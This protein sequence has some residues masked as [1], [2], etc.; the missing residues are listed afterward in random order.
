[1]EK[2]ATGAVIKAFGNLIHV[3]FEGNIKQG[4]VAYV[5]VGDK[6]FA[7]EVIEINGNEAKVQVFEDTSGIKV[8]TPVEFSRHLLEAE[9][10]PGLLTSIFDGLQNPLEQIAQKAGFF[11]SRGLYIKALDRD[12]KWA[13]T[14]KVKVDDRVKRGDFLGEVKESHFNH[15][16]MTPFAIRTALTITWVIK[17]G[18][19]NIDTIIAK[20]K[21]ENGKEYEISMVQRWPVKTPLVEGKRQS[22]SKMLTTG[23][24]L[25]DTPFPVL[26]GATFCTP[27]PFGAGKT[28]LQHHLAKHSDVDIVIVAACGERAGEV[29]EVLREFPRLIDAKTNEPLMNRTVIIC[30]TSS[31]PVAAREASVYMAVTIAEYYRQMGLDILVLADSTSR[32]AQAMREM[33][34]RLEEIPGEEAFPAY[35]ASRIAAFYERAGVISLKDEKQGSLT[36]GGAVSPAGGNFEEPVTQATLSVVGAFW[37]LSRERSDAR[38]YP[39]I[40]PLIS[41][42]KY[43]DQASKE[44]N[45]YSDSW[46]RKVNK[47]QKILR[48]G[49]EILKRMEVVGEEGI[50]IEDMILYLKAELY[51]MCYLQQN[52]F[53]PIDTYSP[54][55][56][57]VMMFD[58]L[59]TIFD[60]TFKF[61]STDDARSFFLDLQNDLKNVNYLVFESSEFKELIK[62][63]KNK[64]N[65]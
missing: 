54:I 48:H 55:N 42:T 18:S 10:G 46:K 52:S 25:L 2:K 43:L 8:N 62:R 37:G 27:G 34:G 50:S 13:F 15:Q 22:P 59:Q 29:V 21:D 40:D 33:S 63:I 20:A 17:S 56:R 64:L 41:W 28:V 31:M 16:I 36:I 58:L 38:R 60:K 19:Y 32:W 35:L 30:N 61:D 3:L 7:S 45:K 44:L 24:R 6:S 11:L 39:A 23:M 12:K 4:E 26:K 53:D 14:P 1:M 9:L 51:D 65:I 49:N 47:A 57:S 5:K